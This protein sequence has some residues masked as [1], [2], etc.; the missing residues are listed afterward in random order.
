MNTAYVLAA[1]SLGGLFGFMV[2]AVLCMRTEADLPEEDEPNIDTG[3]LDFLE[4]SKSHISRAEPEYWV[5]L[6]QPNSPPQD[7]SIGIA[8]RDAID[9]A[10]AKKIKN[11]VTNKEPAHG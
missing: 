9:R 11:D 4:K 5:I 10:W 1:F 8:L 3:R 7:A 2:C 6:P